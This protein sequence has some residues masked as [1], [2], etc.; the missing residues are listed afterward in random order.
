MNQYRQK[1][2]L[3]SLVDIIGL[4]LLG[5]N[6][7]LNSK[8]VEANNNNTRAIAELVEGVKEVNRELDRINNSDILLRLDKLMKKDDLDV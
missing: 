5:Y 7:Y 8:Q 6:V 4:F 2:S 3:Q 1:N